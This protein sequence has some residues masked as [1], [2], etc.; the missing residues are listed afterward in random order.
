MDTS[1]NAATRKADGE[2]VHAICS[3]LTNLNH[4]IRT[5]MNGVAG[6]LELLLDTELTPPQQQ[7]AA[8]ARHSAVELMALIEDIVDFS[9]IAANRFEPAQTPFDL[10]AEMQAA[11]AAPSAAAQAKG[12]ALHCQFPSSTLVRGDPARL[13]QMIACL[14]NGA[15]RLTA[16]GTISIATDVVRVN[17][18]FCRMRMTI[19][20]PE[21]EQAGRQSLSLLNQPREAGFLTLRTHNRIDLELALCGQLAALMGV[22]IG[23]EHRPRQASIVWFATELPCVPALQDAAVQASAC[24]PVCDGGQVQTVAGRVLVAD[25]NPVNQQVAQ[26]MVEK[27]GC[28]VDVVS[29]GAEAVAMHAVHPYDLI[30]MD[31]QMPRVDGYQATQRIRALEGDERHTPV[32]ALTACATQGERENCLANGMDDFIAK[33]VRPQTL[34]E[35]LGRWLACAVEKQRAAARPCI[36]ELDTVSEAFGADFAELAR[37]YRH[38]SPPRIAA[39]YSAAAAGDRLQ[40]AKIAHAFAGSSASIGATGLSA[41]CKELERCAKADTPDDFT[42]RLAA[43]ETEYDRISGKLQAMRQ[44]HPEAT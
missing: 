4:E 16:C 33:P 27:L 38:D 2:A 18:G 40:V 28:H 10:L 3:L 20:V 39:L 13:R 1:A 30:L 5:S 17:D 23:V 7:F 24:A 34:K 11:C 32:I 14:L 37:L 15:I 35:V 41:L 22:Q 36:D 31:C 43:I 44:A 12:L 6:M 25:D 42:H 29:D 9:T 21:P 8:T 26:C 19:S